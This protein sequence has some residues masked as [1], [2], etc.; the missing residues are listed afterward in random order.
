MIRFFYD[1]VAE[2][3][4]PTLVTPTMS[5]LAAAMAK[6][7]VKTDGESEGTAI[8]DIK[9]AEQPPN[10]EAREKAQEATPATTPGPVVPEPVKTEPE[11]KA[12]VPVDWK[13]LVKKQPETEVLKHLGF[14]DKMLGF[15]QNWKAGGDLKNYLEA[16]TIDYSKMSPED[17]MRRQLQVDYPGIPPEDF[18]EFYRM[19]VT[20]QYKLDPDLF[21]EQEIKRG[22]IL[23]NADAKRVRDGLIKEQQNYLLP[24]APE[25]Q[26]EVDTRAEEHEKSMT[27]YKNMV[28]S[29]PYTKDV[30]RNKS[31]VIGEG[32]DKFS[33]TTEAPEKLLDILYDPAKW[34][35]TMFNEDGTPKVEKQLLMAAVAADDK[36][37]LN[38]LKKHYMMLGAKN[39]ID[40]IENASKPGPNTSKGEVT[41]QNIAQALAKGGVIVSG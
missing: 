16:L 14:D 38:E 20:E 30:L 35:A 40:P 34:A 10:V 27:E 15:L 21:S 6:G 29:N 32:D 24:K 3:S 28:E 22:R 11:V 7:G 5:D 31:I 25:K 13:E 17:V 36:T 26:E 33:Y 1:A 23:L 2:T 19:K 41:F 37:F 12:P 39:I 4:A 9:T 18:E 8:P